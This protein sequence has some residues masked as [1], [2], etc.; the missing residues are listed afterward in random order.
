MLT[1]GYKY[2]FN[3]TQ[4]HHTAFKSIII[5]TEDN[6]LQGGGGGGGFQALL[7]ENSSDSVFSP[8]LILQFHSGVYQWLISKQY[9]SK[10]SEGVRGSNISMGVPNANFK[11]NP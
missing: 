3:L 7:P 6:F 4:I 8:Q 5:L 9:F 1:P 2:L 10:V 11:R